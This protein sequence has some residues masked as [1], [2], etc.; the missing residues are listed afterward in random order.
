MKEFLKKNLGYIGLGIIVVVCLLLIVPNSFVYAGYGYNGYQYI[1]R[2]DSYLANN[3]YGRPSAAGIIA[4]FM[5]LFAILAYISARKSTPALI[6]GGVFLAI[7]GLLFVTMQGW[8][9]LVYKTSYVTLQSNFINWPFYVGG[10]LMLTCGILS[11]Y[12]GASYYMQ[13]KQAAFR[14]SG[15]S[16]LKS[17]KKDDKKK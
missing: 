17:T 4:L 3:N 14:S 7:A 9:I 13:E 16:Y 6:T 10:V 11:M 5:M 15:Y 8:A 1:F 2:A 12:I